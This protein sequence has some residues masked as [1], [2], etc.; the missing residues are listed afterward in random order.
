MHC[1]MGL[2]HKYS[3]EPLHDHTVLQTG[4]LDRLRVVFKHSIRE[5][6]LDCVGRGKEVGVRAIMMPRAAC[7][8]GADS[9]HER[10]I[11]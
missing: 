10:G 7:E 8:K 11:D 9:W 3:N 1:H 5:R 6:G 2:E 4:L